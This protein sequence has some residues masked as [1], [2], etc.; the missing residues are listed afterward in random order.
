AHAS[1]GGLKPKLDNDEICPQLLFE[2]NDWSLTPESRN[3]LDRKLGPWLKVYPQVA[4]AGLIVEGWADS[5]GTEE[6]CQK[7]SLQRAQ[8][9]AKYITE[10]LGYMCS[11]VGKGKSFDPPNSNEENKQQNRRVVIKSAP[12][13]VSGPTPSPDATPAAKKKRK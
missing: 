11:A 7:V 12:G 10:T 3:I 13:V 1:K 6:A 9:V 2:F 4:Q 5:V 8:N